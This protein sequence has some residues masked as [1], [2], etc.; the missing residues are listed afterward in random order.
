M[1]GEVRL[2]LGRVGQSIMKGKGIQLCVRI[3][4]TQDIKRCVTNR[5]KGGNFVVDVVG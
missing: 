1:V 5:R 4:G 3:L 2:A